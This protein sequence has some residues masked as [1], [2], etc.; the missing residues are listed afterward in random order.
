MT[1]HSDAFIDLD[2]TFSKILIDGDV[3]DDVDLS[4]RHGQSGEFHWAD[5]LSHPRVVLLSEAGSGK[6][7]E[8]RNVTRQLRSE[9]KIAFF[10]RIENVLSEL[11]DAFEEGTWAAAALVSYLNSEGAKQVSTAS[12][13]VA[14]LASNL[15]GMVKR[16]RTEQ[17]IPHK[18]DA[19]QKRPLRSR[20]LF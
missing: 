3:S 8:I 16:F 14:E 13:A 19:G 12:K 15:H 5:L 1:W 18:T 6:T 11:E 20:S 17:A 4:A 9:G 10:L 7:T 2:R